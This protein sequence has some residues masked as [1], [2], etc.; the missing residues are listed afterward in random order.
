MFR[1]EDEPVAKSLSEEEIF[2]IKKQIEKEVS[3]IYDFNW[4]QKKHF[5]AL[6]E[7]N[8]MKEVFFILIQQK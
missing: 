2:L 1:K 6:S 5:D 7:Q 4:D 8:S 3:R